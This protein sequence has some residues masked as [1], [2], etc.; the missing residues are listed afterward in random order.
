MLE[1][2]IYV[3][4]IESDGLLDTITKIHC[5]CVINVKTREVLQLTDYEK[6]RE[7]FSDEEATYIGHNIIRF[8]IPALKKIAWADVKGNI[9]DTLALSWVLEESRKSH[10]LESYGE[11]FGIKK[12]EIKDWSSLTVEEYIFRCSEDVKINTALWTRQIKY[13]RQVYYQDDKNLYRWFKYLRFKLECVYEQETEGL[14]LD[15]DKAKKHF[16][17]LTIL[18]EEKIKELEE[19]MPRVAIKKKRVYKDAIKDDGGNVFEK[20]DLFYSHQPISRKQEEVV[21]EKII[22]W[23][24]PNANSHIQIKNWLYSLGW[25]PQNIQHKRNKKTNE[26]KLIP[27]IKSQF[28]VGEICDSVKLLFEK[29]PKLEA[30]GGL[31]VL[32]HRISIFEGFISDER[33]GRIYPSMNGLTNTLRLKHRVIVNLPRAGRAYGEDIRGCLIADEGCILCGSDLSGIEDSTKRHFIY[34]YDPEYVESMNTPGYD[35]HLELAVLAKFMTQDD[36]DWYKEES[37]RRKDEAYKA[38][39]DDSE[40]FVALTAKRYVAKTTNFAATYKVGAKALSVY[41]G[42]SLG[43]KEAKRVIDTYWKRNKAILDVEESLEVKEIY[44]QKWLFN[45][46]SRFWY[47]LRA[48]KDKFSTLNQSTAVFVFDKWL[49]E[50]RRGGVKIPFQYHDEWAAN[51]KKDKKKENTAIIKQAIQKVNDSLKLNVE[52]GCSVDYGKRYSDIH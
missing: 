29:E 32:T 4:D 31:S 21:E 27:Q 47:T 13:L 9:I 34:D 8:D 25:I 10:G 36:A 43:M 3:F 5:V 49:T 33:D 2:N 40:R 37:K 48:D 16:D 24:D 42:I 51:V 38:S 44:G 22:G 50:V 12:P 15:V 46:V 7:F 20:G 39:K 18:K 45:P 41:P 35:P 11:E 52:I 17:E 26:V 19:A 30:L 23:K 28:E 6:I 14:R 1:N